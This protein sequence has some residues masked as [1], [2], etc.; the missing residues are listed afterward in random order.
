MVNG[1]KILAMIL[2]FTLTFSYFSI[3]TEVIAT[4]SFLSIFG[5]STDTG[6]RNVEFEAYLT[7]GEETA[8]SIVSDVNNENLAI[9]LKL[10]V[11]KSG[12]LKDGKVEIKGE[13]G[14]DLN[15]KIDEDNNI[16]ELSS[17]VQSLEDNIITFNKI[18]YSSD[19]IEISLPIQYQDEEYINEEKLCSTAEV[20]ISGIYVDDDGQENEI[21][22]KIPLTLAWKDERTVKI[23]TEVSKYIQFGQDGIIL[24]TMVKVDHSNMDKN[25]L[26]VKTSELKIDV[27]TIYDIAPTEIRVLANST[28]GTNGKGVGQTQFS[29][30]NWNYNPEEKQIE[31]KVENNKELVTVNKTDSYLKVE[32]D[33]VQEERYYS[34]SGIDEYLITYTFKNI[35]Q[36]EEKTIKTRAEATLTTLSG[37]KADENSQVATAEKVDEYTLTGQTGNIISYNIENETKD[38][39][40]AYAYLNKETE[41]NSK[42]AINISYKDIVE[43]IIVEDV[44]NY[45]IDKAENKVEADDVYYKEVSV[46]KEEFVNILGEEGTIQILDTAGNLLTTLNKDS[47]ADDNGNYVVS[48]KDR[49]SKISIKT[50]A[51]INEGNLV[52]ASKKAVSNI[53]IS[54]TDYANIEYLATSTVQKAKFAFVSDLVE[55]GNCTIKTKLED[56]TTDV[57]LVIDRDSFSTVTTNSNVE[58]RL[59][60]NNNKETSDIYGNSIFEVEM[61]EYITS[62]NLTNASMIYGEGLEISSVEPYVRDDGR[63]MIK[64]SVSG[65][66]NEFNSGVLTNGANIVLNADVTLDIYTPS[67]ETS[68]KAY[69]Y[70]SE[71]TNYSNM[72]EYSIGNATVCDIEEVDIG[73]SAPNGLVA[74][75]TLAN[76]NDLG[77]TVTSVKQGEQVDY[78]DIY[79]EAK[80]ST[81]DIVVINNNENS[82]SDLSILGRIPFKGVKDIATGE[83]LGT[84]VDTKLVSEIIA[85]EENKGEFTIYYSENEEATKDLQDSKNNWVNSPS[86]LANI[87]SYLIVPNASDYKMEAKQVLKFNY[88]YEIPENLSHNENIYGTFLANYTNN[89]EVATVNETTKPDLVGLT[90]GAGPELELE[91]KANVDSVKENDEIEI[92]TTVKNTGEDIAQDVV[93]N[94]PLPVNTTFIS[95]EAN[96][97]I[98][99]VECID[100]K[101]VA[102]IGQLSK[103]AS[104]DIKSI[105]KVGKIYLDEKIKISATTIAKDLLTELKSNEIEINFEKAIFRIEQFMDHDIQNDYYFEKDESLNLVLYAENLTNEDKKDVTVVTDLPK[106]LAFLEAYMVEGNAKDG[107]KQ[108]ENATYDESTNKITWKIDQLDAD[109]G[110]GL[111]LHV[112]V[113]DLD[114]GTTGETVKISSQI[115]AEG[116]D[117]YKAEDIAIN[118]G[119]TSISVIQTTSTA[120]Y[121]TEG[122]AI[123]YA[124]AIK[125]EG[126][127]MA[128]DILLTDIIPE[129]VVVKEISYNL[130][131][132]NFTNK[133]SET[134]IAELTLS[135]PE[136]SQIDV[137]VMAVASSLDGVQEKTVT[138]E[139]TVSGENIEEVKSNLVTHII[140]AQENTQD[141]EEISTSNESTSSA[142]ANNNNNNDITKSYKIT[143]TA[144]LDSN[145]NGMREDSETRMNNVTAMLVDSSTGII[146][147]TT[148]TNNNGEY[149]FAGLQNGSYLVLFK[150]DTVLYTTTTYK[151][152]GIE[153]ALNSDAVT[154]KIE[155]DGKK[156]NGAV[157]DVISINGASVSN[158]DIGF[159]EAEQFSLELD[160]SISKVTVQNSQGTKTEEFDK[161]KLAKY[162]IAAKYLS[163]TTVYVEYTFTVTNNGDLSGFATEIIDYIPQGMT[164]N[165]SLN[166]DWYTGTDGN[167]YTKA[168][169]NIELA[170]GESKDITLVLTKQ[171]TAENTGLVSNTAEIANDYNIYGVSDKNSTPVNKAQGEDDMSTAD[172]ILTVKT[173]ESLIYISGIIISLMLGSVVAFIVYERVLK[174][175][176]KGGV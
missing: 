19:E 92:I 84:T 136:N 27:P 96:K 145:A 71:A 167:L 164:F 58:I 25:S 14:K 89:T 69:C 126:S 65:M 93:V 153:S 128:R 46:N 78:I 149:K 40:K 148:T 75:N 154:T 151:K 51:P 85:N 157:T 176:R 87:K 137:N 91:V 77:A 97:D 57:N 73:Y 155:Q 144:W 172:T 36:S 106:E 5:D 79:S 86:N 133:M 18:E 115:F 54:K 122:D 17:S 61:P 32:G 143:G 168:L 33:E 152:E 125:N 98:N 43:E 162:D 38:M 141:T 60:L 55:L 21:S 42:T 158:I 16:F 113:G 20:I 163:G 166:P 102:N 130:D 47:V 131:G 159:V 23:E 67:Q 107:I 119:K 7:N 112:K 64:V 31:I 139:G 140:Q 90:T 9:K 100:G 70:N 29:D 147:E 22:K 156:E 52:V 44:Q 150:Y 56:T 49:I 129:G 173:G 134:D 2:V 142:G 13:E 103:D 35:E 110:K 160:K 8:D 6:N 127:S 175:K 15:F 24:Q 48:F 45:Y 63:V 109:T 146:K 174:S 53:S 101:V 26:P 116:T 171:M 39:S 108:V 28:A 76:Y 3:V 83:D 169:E 165:S 88:T 4:T 72:T 118:V 30:E 120:T 82:I 34:K 124:F 50:S 95:A 170:K 94:M 12:Y 105:V 123:N 161:A 41:Y 121:V 111:R 68:I 104:V 135:V 138:N 10:D 99:S 62:L 1:K 66:Q 37:V 80:T 81:M 114:S 74:I 117:I 132:S 59:E 11:S